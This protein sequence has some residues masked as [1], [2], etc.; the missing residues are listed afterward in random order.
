MVVNSL[1]LDFPLY[2]QFSWY[3]HFYFY[4]HIDLYDRWEMFIVVWQ[5]VVLISDIFL[6]S[7]IIL[8]IWQI[9]LCIKVSTSYFYRDVATFSLKQEMTY[10]CCLFDSIYI[11]LYTSSYLLHITKE[12]KSLKCWNNLTKFGKN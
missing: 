5:E 12:M 7:V 9:Y 10:S 6:P 1:H 8:S 11:K 3:S 2:F 4:S